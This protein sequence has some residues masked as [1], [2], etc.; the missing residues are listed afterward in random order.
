MS[1]IKKE[2]KNFIYENMNI[3]S[4]YLRISYIHKKYN[5]LKV[6]LLVF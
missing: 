6:L 2:Q 5:F 1:P 4:A 3:I